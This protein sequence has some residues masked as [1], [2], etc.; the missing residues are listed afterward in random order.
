MFYLI[1]KVTGTIYCLQVIQKPLLKACFRKFNLGCRRLIS[2][3]QA[4]TVHWHQF[5]WSFAC[6]YRRSRNP[7][8]FHNI[9]MAPYCQLMVECCNSLVRP[10]KSL[11]ME[12]VS[13]RQCGVS[14]AVTGALAHVLNNLFRHSID[15]ITE[16]GSHSL[17]MQVSLSISFVNHSSHSHSL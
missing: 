17:P 10:V 15:F 4:M 11:M 8:I 5:G 14:A 3:A 7:F 9:S 1:N 2:S 6:Q 16:E 12:L 13:G